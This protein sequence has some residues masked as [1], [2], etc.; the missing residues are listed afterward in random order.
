M[1]SD[2]N[3][4]A[5]DCCTYAKTPAYLTSPRPEED[6]PD[7]DSAKISKT[8]LYIFCLPEQS[9]GTDKPIE[10]R[11]HMHTYIKINVKALESIFLLIRF[12]LYF[13]FCAPRA[14]TLG[15]GP[16]QLPGFWAQVRSLHQFRG[17]GSGSGLFRHKTNKYPHIRLKHLIKQHFGLLEF[18]KCFAT[19]TCFGCVFRKCVLPDRLAREFPH[20][21]KLQTC[22]D[23]IDC[24]LVLLIPTC[25]FDAQNTP[26]EH[27]PDLFWRDL[28]WRAPGPESRV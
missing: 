16:T 4:T 6:V 14:R 11:L 19:K 18:F 25:K 20:H 12:L 23:L 27:L 15:S 3:L 24:T 22:L 8:K 13:V 21:A 1:N 9:W 2:T 17:V 7:K 5:T 10:I 26:G 28:F